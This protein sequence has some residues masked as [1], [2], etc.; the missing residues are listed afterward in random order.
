MTNNTKFKNGQNVKITHHTCD[1]GD[2]HTYLTIK[3]VR[4]EEGETVLDFEKNRRG[5]EVSLRAHSNL[6]SIEI[7]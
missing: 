4:F 2:V 5:V 6:F 1:A 7:V 3:S